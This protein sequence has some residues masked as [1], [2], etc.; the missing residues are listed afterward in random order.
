MESLARS[1]FGHVPVLASE[2]HGKQ[3]DSSC[4]D[5]SPVVLKSRQGWAWQGYLDQFDT[6][7]VQQHNSVMT[8]HQLLSSDRLSL[9]PH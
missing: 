1:D 3:V 5:D 9:F 7:V 2:S 6:L 4:Y 8:G